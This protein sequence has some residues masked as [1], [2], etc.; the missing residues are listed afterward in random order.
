MISIIIPVYNSEQYLKRCIDSILKQTFTDLEI[1]LVDDGSTDNSLKICEEYCKQDN[2]I[3]VIH[4]E[5]GGSTSAR[6]AGVCIARGEYIAFVDSDDWIDEIFCERLYH[7]AITHQA[8]IAASGCVKEGDCQRQEL[9]NNFPEGYYSKQELKKVIYPS[10]LYYEDM[11]LFSFG[12]RQYMW[13]K[14]FRKSI[15]EQC[16]YSL[17]ERLYDGED[18]A[19]VYDACLR[20]SSIVIDNHTYYHYIVHEGSICTSVRDEKYFTNAVYLYQYMMG[21][22]EK[23]EERE[24]M[25]PQLKHFISMFM[26]NGMRAV[27]GCGYHK[28]YAAAIWKLPDIPTDKK[29]RLVLFGA[30]TMGISYYRQL[31]DYRNVEITGWV[32]SIAYG[33]KIGGILIEFP[34]VIR[35]AEWDYIL[36]AVRNALDREQIIK[37]LGEMGATKEKILYREAERYSNLYEFCL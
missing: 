23:S 34:E 24:V 37:K 36:I 15:I 25:I 6:K 33:R 16:I 3:Y 10:M 11:N 26:N 31:L 4:K 22:F 28:S 29:C 5:N 2:R 12:I 7:E 27:F 35:E 21:I 8:D 1:I 17:D 32:D 9:V 19:C 18:V 30:G 20:A 13:G 14:L